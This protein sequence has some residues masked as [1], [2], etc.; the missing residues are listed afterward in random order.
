MSVKLHVLASGSSGNASVLEVGCFGVLLDFGLPARTLEQRLQRRGLSWKS[1]HAVLLSHP[2]ADH[3]RATT[4]TQLVKRG[5]PLHC[6]A[7]HATILDRDSRAFADLSAAGLVRYY[8]PGQRWNLHPDCACMPIAVSHDGSAT[9]GFRFEGT[10]SLLGAN[11]WA[12]GYA[13]DLGCWSVE[14]AT[15]FADVD[16]LALEFNHDVA[17]Q[18][19]SGRHPVLIRR[20]LSDQGH[21]SNEQA[22]AF[23]T[24]VLRHSEPGRLR[25]LVQLH[26]SQQC[27]RPELAR[28]AGEEVVERLGM[29]IAIHTTQQGK[30]GPTIGLGEQ[31]SPAPRRSRVARPRAFVQPLLPFALS[32]A[33]DP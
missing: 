19:N 5:L 9:C 10:R 14:L 29:G 11:P 17:M 6:H 28:S 33:G 12:I 31:A 3:R 24:E 16:I 21:L 30:A 15:Q 26:L 25:S 18:L 23:M 27:N 8:E 32:E 22:A 4:L 13:T 1:I 7:E 2:H 20:V